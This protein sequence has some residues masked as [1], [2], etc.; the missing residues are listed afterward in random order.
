MRQLRIFKLRKIKNR[1]KKCDFFKATTTIQLKMEV[2]LDS[3]FLFRC[4]LIHNFKT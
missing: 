3:S 4:L 2:S 1:I